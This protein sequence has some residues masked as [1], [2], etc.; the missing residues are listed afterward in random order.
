MEYFGS[1]VVRLR[2]AKDLLK[3][4]HF[5]HGDA[6]APHICFLIHSCRD[7]CLGSHVCQIF[8]DFGYVSCMGLRECCIQSPIIY[9]E[10]ASLAAL[11]DQ[12]ISGMD[13]AVHDAQVFGL[14]QHSAASIDDGEDFIF[15]EMLPFSALNLYQ[16]FQVCETAQLTD[17]YAM[18]LF[19]ESFLV[20]ND[21]LVLELSKEP[22]FFFQHWRRDFGT[23]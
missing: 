9:F 16:S 23:Y 19:E 1:V 21:I 4:A 14:Y 11:L 17:Y 2:V 8:L 15:T 13:P 18:V 10:D 5:I 22:V 3:C 20:A 7:Y 6:K 12:Y